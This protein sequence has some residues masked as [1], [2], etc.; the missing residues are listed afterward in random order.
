MNEKRRTEKKNKW[1]E[2]FKEMRGRYMRLR[3]SNTIIFKTVNGELIFYEDK[4][5]NKKKSNFIGSENQER[6]WSTWVMLWV[7]KIKN[8]KILR[9]ESSKII[10]GKKPWGI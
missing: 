6:K 4:K 8:I 5:T 2:R 9:V 3:R 10:K 1:G 7:G